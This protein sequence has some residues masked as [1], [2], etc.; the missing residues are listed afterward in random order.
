MGNNKNMP[1]PQR[2]GLTPGRKLSKLQKFILVQCRN[3]KKKEVQRREFL[4]FYLDAVKKPKKDDQQNIITKSLMRL[5]RKDL[6]VGFGEITKEKIFVERVRITR[7]GRREVRKIL[8]KQQKL[9][10]R[11]KKIRLSVSSSPQGSRLSR[12]SSNE[13]KEE[14]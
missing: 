7:T 12:A 6:L 3:L 13:N 1:A 14:T 4:K 2:A 11:L 5:I 10:L 9:P 8:D